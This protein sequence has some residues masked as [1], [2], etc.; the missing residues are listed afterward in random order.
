[1]RKKLLC[2]ASL[3]VIAGLAVSGL[4]GCDWGS[5]GG[6][7]RD[8]DGDVGRHEPPERWPDRGHDRDRGGWRDHDRG[9]D[10]P[11]RDLENVQCGRSRPGRV[12]FARGVLSRG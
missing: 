7:D 9:H 3:V 10:Q 6:R 11:K 4:T 5:G 8:R 1:M 12:G 2:R